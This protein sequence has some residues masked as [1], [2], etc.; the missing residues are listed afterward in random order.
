MQVGEKRQAI[1][2]PELGLG[3]EGAPGLIPGN[4]TLILQVELVDILEKG[5]NAPEDVSD[6]DYTETE[7]GLKIYD[8]EEGTGDA[9]QQGQ[10]V[11]VHY[12]GW[13][14]DGTK[15]DS[16]YD[17]GEPFEVVVGIGQVIP[18]WDEGL[19]GMKEGGRRQLVIPP[20]LAYGEQGSGSI[21][22]NATLIFDIELIGIDESQN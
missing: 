5:P 11:R 8:L 20:E 9:V 22:P 16:S 6:S 2:P 19:T 18:G 7:S 13:L 17:R 14:E 12:T 3:E 21:P 15:F 1:I 10:A 4:A